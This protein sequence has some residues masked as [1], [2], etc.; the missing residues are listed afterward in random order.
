MRDGE[1]PPTRVSVAPDATPDDPTNDAPLAAAL[2]L[3][4][5]LGWFL[6]RESNE[7]SRRRTSSWS[8]YLRASDCHFSS[9][10]FMRPRSSCT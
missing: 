2:R 8:V 4:V 1:H 5:R 10:R 9:S 7:F 3:C 6:S